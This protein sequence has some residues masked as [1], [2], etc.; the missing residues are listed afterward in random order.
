MN[1]I[2]LDADGLIKLGKISLLSSLARSYSCI[3]SKEVFKEVIEEGKRYFHK[4]AL[5]LESYIKQGIIKV[6][7]VKSNLKAKKLLQKETSLGEGEKSSLHL[8][9]N[10]N[11]LAIVS[12]DIAFLNLLDKYNVPYITPASLISRLVELKKI[13]KQKGL[14]MLKKLKPYIRE[15]IYELVKKEIKV[16]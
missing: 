12:D 5:I 9:Y 13:S 7:P 11:A 3:I 4:D 2:I 15:S 6:V 10:Q 1:F 8:F 14:A 16:S